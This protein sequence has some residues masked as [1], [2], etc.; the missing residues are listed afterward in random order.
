MPT[1]KIIELAARHIAN[2]SAM[3]SSAIVCLDEAIA[4]AARGENLDAE[5]R[6]LHSLAYSVGIFHA[7][8][9]RAAELG[10]HYDL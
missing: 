9:V 4:L 3:Q 10:G 6:A 1:E 5:R 7:D 8:Y 2:G